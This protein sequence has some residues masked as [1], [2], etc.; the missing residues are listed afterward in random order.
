MNKE[1]NEQQLKAI[2]ESKAETLE[3][4]WEREHKRLKALVKLTEFAIGIGTAEVRG[5]LQQRQ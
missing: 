5:I 4:S 1:T 2:R 3:I